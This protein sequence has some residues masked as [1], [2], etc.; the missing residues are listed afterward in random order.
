MF[1]SSCTSISISSRYFTVFMLPRSALPSAPSIS[2]LS[3]LGLKRF[4]SAITSR[5]VVS[6]VPSPSSDTKAPTPSPLILTLLPGL[7]YSALGIMITLF[8]P[9][10]STFCFKIFKLLGSG[11]IAITLPFSLTLN[12]ARIENKPILAP[13]SITTSPSLI[14][15]SR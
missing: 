10:N 14:L 1:S 4:S 11:S 3:I 12:D 9:F 7:S 2:I 8:S 5:V 15:E 6:T 13:A